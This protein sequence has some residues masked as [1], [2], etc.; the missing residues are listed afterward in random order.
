MEKKNP[1][2]KE[3][4]EAVLPLLKSD[5]I[6]ARRVYYYLSNQELTESQQQ[7]VTVFYNKYENQL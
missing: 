7:K 6:T 4:S 1:N 5:F 3:I 2:S